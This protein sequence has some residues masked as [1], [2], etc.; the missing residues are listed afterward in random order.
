MKA[1]DLALLAEI[2]ESRAGLRLTTDQAY[3]V[4]SRLGPLAAA[5]HPPGLDGLLAAL[6]GGADPALPTAVTEALVDA[7]TVFFRDR[8]TFRHLR[9]AVLPELAARRNGPVRVWSAAC[10]T[11]QEPYSLA[12]IAQ[13]QPG[14]TLDLCASDLS[15]RALQKARAGIYTQF[16][17]QRGLPVAE[18]LRSFDK[19]EDSWR[20]TAEL[21][22]VV[23]WR[24]FNLLDD[25][26]TLGRFD[27]ILCRYV[28]GAM[29]AQSR[30]TVLASLADA[31]GPGG[32]LV[33]GAEEALRDVPDMF[34]AAPGGRG[35]FMIKSR[36][37]GA[38]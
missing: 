15:E 37:S 38:A 4:E 29:T 33:L 6:R 13:V 1:V 21:R 34:E 3:Q 8:E 20:M 16:E 18:L 2:V 25:M 9:E 12:M 32:V 30:R 27:L 26:T 11:G 31:L 7:N 10:G 35:L 17:V 22:A 14:L 5:A 28:L 23:R 36:V 24:R 19:L